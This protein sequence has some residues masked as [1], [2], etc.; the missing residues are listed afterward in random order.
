[1]KQVLVL[2]GFYFGESF[3]KAAKKNGHRVILVDSKLDKTS[4]LYASV[5]EFIP[6][7]LTSQSAFEDIIENI[8]TRTINA[9]VPGHVFHVYLQARLC[10]F[11][12]LPSISPDAASRCLNKDLMRERFSQRGIK[13]PE[14]KVINKTDDN[15]NLSKMDYP[16]VIKPT[17]GFAS[18][19]V[20]F[21]ENEEQARIHIEKL[22][23]GW[24][25]SANENFEDKSSILIEEKLIGHEFSAEVLCE[26]GEIGIIG[27]TDKYFD[28]NINN[29]ELGF[30]LP[31]PINDTQ[32]QVIY[33][34]IREAYQALEIDHG[35]S[36]CEF[37][38][39]E[40]GPRIVDLN[41]RVGGAHLADVYE[42][43]T[44]H[45]LFEVAL[46][47]ALGEKQSLSRF[48]VNRAAVSGWYIGSKGVVQSVITPSSLDEGSRMFV[49]KKQ[50][51]EILGEG[52][53]RDRIIAVIA[54]G[55]DIVNAKEIL[56]NILAECKVTYF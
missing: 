42:F 7:N 39:T 3:I 17:N 37:V 50:G 47:N 55:K 20:S 46:K 43:A 8:G 38:L 54:S 35:I 11:Y 56:N 26:N 23:K 19:S 14:Y 48:P 5:D 12:S 9:I 49:R 4:S 16:C 41:P 22:R 52:D 34:Y 45:N 21:A 13:Q 32:F 25:Y 29:F 53:N 15:Y 40:A 24:S 51:T 18:I 2:G 44:G 36:H 31:S 30:M 27:I 28:N 1:M 6:I 10:N 33:N